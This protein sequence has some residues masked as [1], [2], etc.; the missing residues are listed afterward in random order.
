MN[1]LCGARLCLRKHYRCN[2]HVSCPAA[3]FEKVFSDDQ[4]S[5][6]PF[7]ARAQSKVKSSVKCIA[8]RKSHS[9]PSELRAHLRPRISLLL[10]HVWPT[11]PS[12]VG[13]HCFE[14]E[15][16]G[17][18]RSEQNSENA[19]ESLTNSTVHALMAG[20]THDHRP[21]RSLADQVKCRDTTTHDL[22]KIVRNNDF[23]R[24]DPGY[25]RR[26]PDNPGAVSYTHLT[27][28]TI[29]SV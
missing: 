14:S 16:G 12:C 13:R 17:T 3:C 27:L 4:D 18:P 1:G 25:S 7:Q 26:F 9:H 8:T 24:P 11:S 5:N 15:G 6:I 28:P 23:S 20:T 22:A 21:D 29:Y 2:Q 10:L 19:F